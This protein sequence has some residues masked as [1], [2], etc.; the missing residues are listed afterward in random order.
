MRG[1][2]LL[3]LAAV[4]LA[5]CGDGDR[6]TRRAALGPD[7]TF[8]DYR[9]AADPARGAR[10]FNACAG[11][12]PISPGALDRGGP[13]LFGI[14]GRP[15]ATVSPRFGYSG[16]LRALGGTWTPERMDRWVADPHKLV[17]RTSMTFSG[18][19]DPLDRAD[20]IAWME[21]QRP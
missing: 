4:A 17:P 19:G 2:A 7:P 5:G 21:T 13:N 20:L 1:F 11:C 12:H 8:A 18:I 15:V 16:A 6:A 3:A 10:L 9:K 14:M